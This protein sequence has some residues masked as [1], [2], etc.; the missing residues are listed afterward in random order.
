MLVWSLVLDDPDDGEREA[1]HKQ[2]L[3]D[4]IFVPK[5]SFA[6]FAP[7]T[8][9]RRCWATSTS[10]RNRPPAAGIHPA[11]LFESWD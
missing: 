6:I 10:F 11:H 9:T 2:H 3:A 4:R 5:I 1:V 8:S 7:R